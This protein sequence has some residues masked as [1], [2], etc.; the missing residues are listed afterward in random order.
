[1]L[2][3]LPEL[4]PVTA[5]AAEYG[6]A[7]RLVHRWRQAAVDHLPDLFADPAVAARAARR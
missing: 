1:M 6:I 7:P 2:E 5:M 3:M 4:R